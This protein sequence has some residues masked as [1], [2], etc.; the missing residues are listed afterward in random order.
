M[1]IREHGYKSPMSARSSSRVEVQHEASVATMAETEI[2]TAAYRPGESTGNVVKPITLDRTVNDVD[3]ALGEIARTLRN[4]VE[5]IAS[6][7][8]RDEAASRILE[9]DSPVL[10]RLDEPL[11]AEIALLISGIEEEL[12]VVSVL[13]GTLAAR[14]SWI[15]GQER[16]KVGRKRSKVGR[17]RSEVGR[18]EAS[19]LPRRASG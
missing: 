2:E 5:A 7:A 11:D 6:L 18:I 1:K 14:L 4:E 8:D 13:A 3:H 9:D 19:I 10:P 16:S 12:A 17:N 15:A